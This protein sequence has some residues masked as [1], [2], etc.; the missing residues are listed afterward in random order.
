M[1]ESDGD[2]RRYF[3]RIRPSAARSGAHTQFGERA[4]EDDCE[5]IAAINP[6]LPPGS[7][8]RDVFAHIDTAIGFFYLLWLTTEEARQLG[9]TS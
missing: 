7:D 8:V 6:L 1:A 4:F 2:N 5:L 9:W 3:A